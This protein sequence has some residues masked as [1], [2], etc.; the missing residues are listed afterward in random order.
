MNIIFCTS[1]HENAVSQFPHTFARVYCDN[2]KLP[3]SNQNTEGKNR[4][5][6]REEETKWQ[7]VEGQGQKIEAGRIRQPHNIYVIG[8]AIKKR[9]KRTKKKFT[10]QNKEQDF[11]D[12]L[13]KATSRMM[14]SF[15]MR[16]PKVSRNNGTQRWSR[17]GKVFAIDPVTFRRVQHFGSDQEFRPG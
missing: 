2:K 5:L 4:A 11:L 1:S 15:A 17:G 3:S 13:N 6:K 10:Q 7:E 16:S 9:K 8:L 12:W 14:K